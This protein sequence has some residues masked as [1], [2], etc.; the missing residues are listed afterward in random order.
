MTL[1]FLFFSFIGN[2][3]IV[4]I[5]TL[6]ILNV[7]PE[8]QAKVVVMLSMGFF[9]GIFVATYQVTAESLFLNKLSGSLNKAFLIS[10]G[11]GIGIT[12]IFSFFQ[13]RIRFA[14]LAF[15]SMVL[16]LVC[17]TALNYFYHFGSTTLRDDVLLLMFCLVGPMTALLLLC[18]WGLFSRLFDFKQSK[19][20]IGWIDT[21]QLA[22]II[23]ANFL[24]PVSASLFPD[25]S[26][27]LIVCDVSIVGALV[28]LA[29][30]GFKFGLNKHA[31]ISD[32]AVRKE[33]GFSKIFKDK[34]VVLL[35]LFLITSVVTLNF[36]QFIFQNLLN[37]QY[38]NQRDLTNFLAY[39][40]GA[41]YLL[42]LAM[43]TF[44][45]DR[46]ISSYGLRVSLFILPA[47][48]GFFAVA[49]FVAA[50]VFGYDIALR[51]ETFIYFF[52]FVAMSRLFNNTLRDSLENPVY[53]LMFVPLES[54]TRFGIQVKVEGVVSEVGRLVAGVV[55]FLLSLISF[56]KIVWI[57][58]ILIAL[59]GVYFLIIQK[60][61]AGY[62]T[63]IRS[64]LENMDHTLDK[65]DVGFK[66]IKERLFG[67]L[68]STNSTKSV[69]S[70]K[71]LEKLDPTQV[72]S[73]VNN[74]MKNE[75]E[76]IRDYAQRRM[77]EIKGLSVSDQYVIRADQSAINVE[78]KKVLNKL[79]I[80]A[81]LENG[82][83]ISKQRIQKLARS[84]QASDRQYAAELLLHSS[85]EENASFLIELL[86][87][88]EP[89]VRKT[90]IATSVKINNP[91]II[92]A[93][94]GNLSNPIYS[95]RAI[96]SLILIGGKSLTHLENAFYQTGQST[97]TIL[98]I[99]QVIGRI[100][101][102][103]AKDM[104]WG[105]IDFPDKVVV[106]QV[107]LAL[108]ESAFKAGMSQI[109]RIKYAIENDVADIAW[110][111]NAIESL[112]N[113]DNSQFLKEALEQEDRNDIDHIY[114]LLAM[115]YDTKSIQLVKENIES[116][117]SE[118]TSYALELLDVFL[119][120][121][122]KQKI[123][124]VLDDLTNNEK[125]GRLEIFYPRMKLDNKLAIKF[126]L[127]RDF[128]QSN[129]WTK[130]CAL[131]Q[132]G[133]QKIADFKL[134]L[135][136]QLFNPDRLIREMAGWALYQID[137]VLY[138]SNSSRLGTDNKRWLDR[139][140]IPGA[141]LK[142]RL[143]EKILFFKN[144]KFFE[145]ISGLSLSFLS[146]LS[147]EV[148]MKP[149]DFLVIDERVNNDFFI[150]YSGS[151]QYYEKSRYRMDYE[152]GQFI[153]E[154]IAPVGFANSNLILSKTDSILLKINKDEFYEL[155][156]DNVKLADKVL[157][158]V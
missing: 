84:E 107:L 71:L 52:L 101:G 8:D 104:L 19:K 129:R 63:K 95:N 24:I 122:L 155:L 147:K 13:N 45:N 89:K 109:T 62:K 67:Q 32:A 93:L 47:I 27:Y 74:L 66:Q 73:W 36:N 124:P 61:Y 136:A 135:I 54:R 134:D 22:A 158:Y 64:K 100:G 65:L 125:I 82:G 139:A 152:S 123:I 15:F 99:V 4:N 2:F 14:A 38:P 11:L 16:V 92:F 110:N 43:Q 50:L 10:G 20:I 103:K 142:L 117:T 148:R 40:N 94:I 128:T 138:T 12:L 108:G 69:F 86:A 98:R 70:F 81:I 106:S 90:A 114:M 112:N 146:D 97:Q 33:T 53:K 18:Y 115:L 80:K 57:P 153:G 151:V 116:G 23:I 59:C 83:D 145:N 48:T 79:D 85:A 41:I 132:I 126:L 144:L 35:S 127:N 131:Q 118:G 137:P 91:E 37:E 6:R 49:S 28:C 76:N 156:A 42:S 9:I 55:I 17:T 133:I 60:L 75:E 154:M 3:K 102:Q 141:Q 150:V 44:L 21:G 46:I 7:R 119:S 143:F 58:V 39:F 34:Y 31:S 1:A 72:S 96:S 105:K 51:P 77:N 26:D 78:G 140:I 5:N 56:F 121:Q 87:D 130:A 88:P 25:T 111:L 157:E 113:D 149:E 68:A 30:I 120:D 29:I